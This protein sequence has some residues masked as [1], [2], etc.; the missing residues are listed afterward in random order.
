MF[1]FSEIVIFAPFILF[2]TAGPLSTLAHV[3]ADVQIALVMWTIG[4][5]LTTAA[6]TFFNRLQ[7]SYS[8][9]MQKPQIFLFQFSRLKLNRKLFWVMILLYNGVL[10]IIGSAGFLRTATTGKLLHE[11]ILHVSLSQLPTM[12]YLQGYPE[13]EGWLNESIERGN[14]LVMFH[15]ALKPAF[16]E[17]T[18][19]PFCRICLLNLVVS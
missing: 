1:D 14:G 4:L 19:N 15:V 17:L 13:I 10:P 9:A 18:W 11:F 12:S 7:V 8:R 2:E 3:P 6:T 5:M 16:W